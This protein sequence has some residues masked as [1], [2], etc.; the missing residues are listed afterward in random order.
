MQQGTA[1]SVSLWQ[2]PLRFNPTQPARKC[3][4]MHSLVTMLGVPDLCRI[5][6]SHIKTRASATTSRSHEP[7]AGPSFFD[8]LPHMH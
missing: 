3:S 4:Y 2:R 6:G 1:R 8:P 7:D 5:I